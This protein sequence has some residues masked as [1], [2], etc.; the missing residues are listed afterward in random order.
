MLPLALSVGGTL[1]LALVWARFW[2][3]SRRAVA[4][5]RASFGE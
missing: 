1:V 3:Q 4:A 5:S 2:R